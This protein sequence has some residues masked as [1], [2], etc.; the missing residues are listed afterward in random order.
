[1]DHSYLL[2]EKRI[3]E[4]MEKMPKMVEEYREKMRALRKATREKKES[5]DEKKYLIAT[6]KANTAPAWQLF[7]DEHK[8]K[9]AKDGKAMDGKGNKKDKK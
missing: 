2:R 3:A 5:S 1:M 4:N 7:M 6:G 9:E 8:K